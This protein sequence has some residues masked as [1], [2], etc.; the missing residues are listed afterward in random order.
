MRLVTELSTQDHKAQRI[1]HKEAC[2]AVLGIIGWSK[3]GPIKGTS[4]KDGVR[5]AIEF[6]PGG[7]KCALY[8]VANG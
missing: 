6:V 1:R 8:K 5:S 7:R 2:R 3:T 4:G